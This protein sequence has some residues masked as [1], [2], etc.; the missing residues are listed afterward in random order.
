MGKEYRDIPIVALTANAL[1]GMKELFL[2]QGFNDYLAKPIEIHK[3]DDVLTKWI[4]QEKREKNLEPQNGEFLEKAPVLVIP[5]LDTVWGIRMTGGREEGYRQVLTLFC[6]DTQKRLLLFQQGVGSPGL[7]LEQFTNLVHSIKS[8]ASTIGAKPES[9]EAALLEKAGQSG[10]LEY[11]Q[12]TLPSFCE[13]LEDLE[14]RISVALGLLVE[15]PEKVLVEDALIADTDLLPLFRNFREA[16]GQQSIDD[17]DRF[18]EKLI[19]KV[20]GSGHRNA[21][22]MVSDLVLIGDYEKAREAVDKL[23][24]TLDHESP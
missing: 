24:G 8:A 2:E 20:Q 9:E 19:E 7:S 23:I 10:N 13:R 12:E 1:S 21:L 18:L 11:I 5:G 14:R 22:E 3:L 16:L 6:R 15:E 4:K 17:I